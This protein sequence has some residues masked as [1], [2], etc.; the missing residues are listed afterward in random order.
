MV[1]PFLQIIV[2]ISLLIALTSLSLSPSLSFADTALATSNGSIFVSANSGTITPVVSGS[3]S[4]GPSLSITFNNPSTP[5]NS[6][7]SSSQ[8]SAAADTPTIDDGNLTLTPTDLN[9]SLANT[10]LPPATFYTKEI[11]F[12]VTLENLTANVPVRREISFQDLP[13]I[14]IAFTPTQDVLSAGLTIRTMTQ[15]PSSTDD[16][17]NPAY[18]YLE[19]VKQNLPNYLIKDATISFKVQKTWI[20]EQQLTPADVLLKRYT[21]SWEDI[22]TKFVKEVSG[23]DYYDASPPGFSY[24]A[25]VSKRGGSGSLD[26]T[27]NAISNSTNSSQLTPLLQ[28]NDEKLAAQGDLGAV[29]SLWPYLLLVMVVALVL[30]GYSKLS[31]AG[32]LGKERKPSANAQSSPAQAAQQPVQ[33]EPSRED[34]NAKFEQLKKYIIAQEAAGKSDMQIQQA[35]LAVGWKQYVIDLIIHDAHDPA[36]HTPGSLSAFSSPLDSYITA[37]LAKG[38][39]PAQITGVLVKTGWKKQDVEA[40][41][42]RAK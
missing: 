3:D 41:L 2:L 34:I 19:V 38:Y 32:V 36:K 26:L 27:G 6:S 14:T 1:R 17:L 28:L 23:Q 8:Q 22:P 24:F 39:T 29:V 16:L 35:L 18:V 11:N 20:T 42:K 33:A 10:T 31:K 30:F 9:Q 21:L 5:S 7:N 25:I 37:S 40:A 13:V 12:T 15:R 4:G